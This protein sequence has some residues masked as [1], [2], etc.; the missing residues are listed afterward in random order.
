MMAE[1]I[2]QAIEDSFDIRKPHLITSYLANIY[3]ELNRITD[4]HWREIKKKR[5]KIL[6]RYQPDYF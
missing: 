6:S 5:N 4:R 3:R 1:G 2:N